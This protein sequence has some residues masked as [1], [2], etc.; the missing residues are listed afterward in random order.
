MTQYSENFTV[1][2]FAC[3]CGCGELNDT[4]ESKNARELLQKLRTA[5]GNPLVINC[6]NRCPEHNNAVGGVSHSQ[7]LLAVAFDI[8]T[9]DM[10]ND[11]ILCLVKLAKDTGFRGF[12]LYNTFLHLDVGDGIEYTR[13]WNKS[14][15][16]DLY[17]DIIDITTY[18]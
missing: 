10:D 11:K 18:P 15:N 4:P 5:W 9:R 3:R 12:G 14:D 1:K 16:A 8:S 13:T 6:N 2:E 17:S 7:H